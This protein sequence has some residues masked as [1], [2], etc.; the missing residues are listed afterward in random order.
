MYVRLF[1]I[2]SCQEIY[3]VRY[4]NFLK[5]LNYKLGMTTS[6]Y[7]YCDK[8]TVACDNWHKLVRESRMPCGQSDS[9]HDASSCSSSE[10]AGSLFQ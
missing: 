3:T 7:N 6:W 8:G 4:D 2:E 5:V 9:V 1:K 10:S